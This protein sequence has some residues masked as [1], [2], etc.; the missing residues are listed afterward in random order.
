MGV[1]I[2]LEKIVELIINFIFFGIIFD[3]N[4]M[5][6]FL[7]LDKLYKLK[8]VINFFLLVKKVIF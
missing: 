4:D 6:M 8:L 7:L 2:V 1:F 3:I 5:I